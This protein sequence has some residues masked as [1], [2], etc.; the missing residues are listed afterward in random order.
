M[1]AAFGDFWG[2]QESYWSWFSGVVDSALYPVLLYSAGAQFLGAEPAA[3][4]HRHLL[5]CAA[6]DGACAR[7]Y[8]LKLLI[9]VAFSLPN[10]Y[11]SRLVGRALVGLAALVMA[12]YL[13]LVVL[14]VP[15]MSAE[16]FFAPPA[17]YKI[18]KMLSVVYWSLSGFDSVSTFA[19]EVAS[20]ESTMPR[21]LL[22]ACAIMLLCYALPL[23]AAAATDDWRLWKDGSLAHAAGVV[24][25]SWLSASV[26]AS[27]TLSNW[28][29]YA[30]E[31]LE[32]SFQLLGMAQVGLAPSIFGKRHRT[33]GTPVNAI[34]FQLLI[35][36]L[37]LGFDFEAIMCIDNFFSAAS[38]VLEFAAAFA[39]RV[40]QPE[41]QRPYRVPLS[42]RGIALMLAP[43]VA[44]SIVVMYVTMLVS[45]AITLGA[46][47]LGAICCVPYLYS[48]CAG[49]WTA[50]RLASPNTAF[51]LASSDP[52]GADPE[53]IPPLSLNSAQ[54][55]SR[56]G[57]PIEAQQEQQQRQQQQTIARAQP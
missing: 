29:L 16:I 37:L 27:A 3:D 51:A 22:L 42:T 30:S 11:S 10:V 41:L 54:V 13:L 56:Y 7:E 44:I 25:G 14:A 47:A 12:P 31:L 21:S 35:I 28:G 45:P 17:K 8:S 34:L 43:P 57:T 2:L 19:G 15:K 46:T 32:D 52:G 39:L 6:T 36:G 5:T 18:G 20:P 55:N 9:L 4:S 38:A 48:P 50:P 23:S 1:Q 53:A 33:L 40:S 24:G 49:R 26:V